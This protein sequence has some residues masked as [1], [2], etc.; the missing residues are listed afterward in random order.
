MMNW[1][2][3]PPR[4][5]AAP[6]VMSPGRG[7]IRAIPKSRIFARPSFVRKMFSGLM[8]RWMTPR[9]CAAERPSAIWQAISVA[10]L[11]ATGPARSRSERF[12]PSRSSVTA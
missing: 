4:A 6:V 1:A 11:G 10:R 2:L 5:A 8:S 3:L 9:A 7:P 12:S